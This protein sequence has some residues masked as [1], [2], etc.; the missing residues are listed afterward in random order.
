MKHESVNNKSDVF[1][2]GSA[3]RLD[4]VGRQCRQCLGKRKC[5][6]QHIVSVFELKRLS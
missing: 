6:Q 2:S 4:I 3:T 1:Y 5:V